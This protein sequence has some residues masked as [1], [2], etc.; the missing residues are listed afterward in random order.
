MTDLSTKQVVLDRT[1]AG[2]D[3]ATLGTNLLG[4]VPVAQ[5]ASAASA[6][7]AMIGY[8]VDGAFVQNWSA[9]TSCG[10]EAPA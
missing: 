7:A 4:A 8:G 6:N 10:C 3:G 2:P 9:T 1:T 5:A